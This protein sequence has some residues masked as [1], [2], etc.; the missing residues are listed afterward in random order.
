MPCPPGSEYI[1]DPDNNGE[2]ICDACEIGK[3]DTQAQE[4][5]RKH[6]TRDKNKLIGRKC[7]ECPHG[8]AC[9]GREALPEKCEENTYIFTQYSK[10]EHH[11]GWSEC[12]PCPPG[13][14]NT[15]EEGNREYK[16][17]IDAP[18]GNKA[19]VYWKYPQPCPRGWYQGE[20]GQDDCVECP[21]HYYSANTGQA[22]CTQCPPGKHQPFIMQDS[23]YD[24]QRGKFWDSTTLTCIECPEHTYSGG[25]TTEC[26]ICDPGSFIAHHK[27][28]FYCRKCERGLVWNPKQHS[29]DMCPWGKWTFEEGGL[30]CELCPPGTLINRDKNRC[31]PCPRGKAGLSGEFCDECW[32]DTFASQEGE[33]YCMPCIGVTQRQPSYMSGPKECIY[34]P[35]IIKKYDIAYSIGNMTAVDDWAFGNVG[36]DSTQLLTDKTEETGLSEM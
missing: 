21:T 9:S 6:R 28:V 18:V 4:Y 22:A 5:Y 13:K 35:I 36:K 30:E 26:I 11:H 3:Y 1:M 33:T 23:C 27:G 8:H 19:A 34:D 10:D 20:P 15:I 16:D 31:E 17:C 29:C 25:G 12:A 2:M 24:C 32:D 7:I 14:T